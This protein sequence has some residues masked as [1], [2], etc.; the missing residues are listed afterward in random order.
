MTAPLRVLIAKAGLDGHDRGAKLVARAL[1]D[2]GMEVIYLK[3]M[4]PESIVRTA[5]QEDVSV[6]GVSMLSG[7]HMTLVPRICSLLKEQG[8]DDVLVMAGGTIPPDDWKPLEEKGVGRVFGPETPVEDIVTFV[9][10]W[11]AHG[12]AAS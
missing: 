10:E 12:K 7:A 4:T 8:L 11:A 3:Y 5:M 2:A 6:V 9:R 1:K